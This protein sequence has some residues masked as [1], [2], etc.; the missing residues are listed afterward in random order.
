M[1]VDLKCV[2]CDTPA[3]ILAMSGYCGT[4]DE[5]IHC[6][7]EVENLGQPPGTATTEEASREG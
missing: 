7:F 3:A 4:A 6:P 2:N 5:S 1:R